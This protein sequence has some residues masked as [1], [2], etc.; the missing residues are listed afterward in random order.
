VIHVYGPGRAA[1][2]ETLEDYPP[3]FLIAA[4]GDGSSAS[5]SAQFFIDLRKAGVNVELHL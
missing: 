4:A 2:N 1:A 5:A 3:T